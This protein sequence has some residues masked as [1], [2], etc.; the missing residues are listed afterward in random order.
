MPTH[1]T[2]YRFGAQLIPTLPAD[3]RRTCQRFRQLFDVGL[4]GPDIF[5]Y[6]NIFLDDAA[7]KLGRKF[8]AQ[9]GADFFARV[10]KRLRLEPTEAGR[11]YLYGVLAHYCL[12]SV[13]HPF[14]NVRC[15][16]GNPG[17][18]EIE[19]EFDRYLLVL[20]GKRP[21]HTFDFTRHM[22]LTPGECKTVAEFYGSAT[23]AM[24][25]TSVKNMAAC[26][27]FLQSPKGLRRSA[28]NAA[29]AVT[30]GK[31]NQHIIPRSPDH[32]CENLDQ[33]LLELYD[34]A[35][36]LYPQLLEQLLAHLDHNEP[37]GELFDKNFNGEGETQ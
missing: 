17:H 35:F 13:C 28:L 21:P 24:V 32:S 16:E 20:D 6:H 30:A 27:R 18:M 29:M 7:V 25:S 3:I 36:A 33:P 8:H 14:V 1:Y 34:Q 4:H 5:F 26:T 9:S 10:V 23:S 19:K 22:R 31:F 15:A 12:D 2:H 11:A 37:L